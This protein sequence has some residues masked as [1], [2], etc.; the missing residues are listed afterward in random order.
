MINLFLISLYYSC[1]LDCFWEKHKEGDEDLLS[2]KK[3]GEALST[4]TR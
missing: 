2:I 3:E 4:Y 1:K